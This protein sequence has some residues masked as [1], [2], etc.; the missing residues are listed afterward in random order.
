MKKYRRVL[1]TWMDAFHSNKGWEDP[2]EAANESSVVCESLGYLLRRGK[3]EV[4]LAQTL[5]SDGEVVGRITIP[6]SFL[7][8][9]IKY[10]KV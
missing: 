4:V 2:T 6:V 9:K 3:K 10:L 8:A 1:V 7:C 5:S